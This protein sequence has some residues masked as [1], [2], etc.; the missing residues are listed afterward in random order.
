MKLCKLL[1][2]Y[3]K[4]HIWIY[5]M[6]LQHSIALKWCK[7][8]FQIATRPRPSLELL[9][10]KLPWLI[11]QAINNDIVNGESDF[12][13]KSGLVDWHILMQI[14]S[15]WCGVCAW[16]RLTLFCW[17]MV[18]S[19]PACGYNQFRCPD[20][21]CLSVRQRCDGKADCVDMSDENNCG[22]CLFASL[23]FKHVSMCVVVRH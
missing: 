4:L 23:T 8:F 12:F 18:F 3:I 11:Q 21:T 14:K 22:V 9:L 6:F 1:H 19:L 16:K 17:L 10:V 7:Q 20:G 2:V 15:L 13:I 5:N